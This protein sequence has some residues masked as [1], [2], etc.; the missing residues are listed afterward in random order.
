VIGAA[1]ATAERRCQKMSLTLGKVLTPHTKKF[2]AKLA[3]ERRY[4][5]SMRISCAKR[6]QQKRS[7]YVHDVITDKWPFGLAL[8]LRVPSLLRA[9]RVKYSRFVD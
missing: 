7:A 1:I 4:A 6:R 8:N 5:K 3:K 9:L 2:H